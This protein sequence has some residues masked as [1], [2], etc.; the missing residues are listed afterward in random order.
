M[1]EVNKPRSKAV[2]ALKI[3]LP[4]AFGLLLLW[5]VY[6]NMDFSQIGEALKNEVNYW[7]IL[8]SLVF[9]LMANCF[10]GLRWQL[11]I[12][13]LEDVKPRPRNAVLTTLGTYAVNMALPRAG[14]LWR[15][16]EESRYEKLPFTKLLGT[17]FMD[18]LMDV[19]VVGLIVLGV[20]FGAGNFFLN[21]FSHHQSQFAFQNIL[22]IFTSI[23]LYVGFVCLFVIGVFCFK[24]F[25]NTKVMTKIVEAVSKVLEGLYSIWKMDR[26]GLF[27]LYTVLLWV[28]YF[29]YFY[30][31]FFAF[32]FMSNLGL[33]AAIVAF[34]M[35]SI[36]MA[37]PVQGGIGAWHF[38]V[39]NTLIAYG[40]SS[41]N[42]ATFA[43]VV[44][45][46]QTLWITLVGFISIMVL[47]ILNKGYIR[48]ASSTNEEPV[49]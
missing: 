42:A 15:C 25:R 16:A 34:T 41:V 27:I 29:L 2:S 20:L 28:G 6:R 37:V 19:V 44:H 9:G 39:I 4:L 13:P 22:A 36:A 47:P 48:K 33:G 23:W 3:I 45:T 11:L 10:R 40:I 30:I 49:E 17:L 24:H 21:F 18:R 31:T 12:E 8:L 43:L 14:E 26:K 35:G 7:Y 1:K 32:P 5:L 38:M 46:I